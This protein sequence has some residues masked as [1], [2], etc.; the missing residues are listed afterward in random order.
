MILYGGKL[1][2]YVMR[3]LLA[4]R[5]KGIELTSASPEGGLKSPAFLRLNPIGKV[6]TMV[7]DELVVPES[8]VIVQY[9]EDIHPR[10]SLLPEHVKDRA[11][12]RLI[13]RLADLYV[14]PQL[15]AIFSDKGV[16]V[17]ALKNALGYVDHYLSEKDSHAVGSDF[18]V[19]DCTL[20]PILFFMDALQ[21]K[22]KTAD[23]VA[24]WPK[25]AAYWDRAKMS[26]AG[27]WAIKEM[28]KAFQDFMK[29]RTS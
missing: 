25:L 27:M 21:A 14:M 12:A 26:D 6:P 18:S 4:A 13:S 11:R 7:S 29:S 15:L 17:E 8:E 9:L 19:A 10:P 23:M 22:A 5:A 20:I 24:Q 1:S 28:D 2:P 3:V 16:D